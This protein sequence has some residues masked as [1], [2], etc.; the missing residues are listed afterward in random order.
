M[1][2]R[3]CT[4]AVVII[5]VTFAAGAQSQ[6]D[7]SAARFKAHV[8]FLADD[9]L[10]GR[11]AGTRG[12]EIAARYVAAEFAQLGVAP[13]A[14]GGS[15]FQPVALLEVR[16][17]GSAWLTMKTSSGS[18]RFAQAHDVL[19]GG[20]PLGGESDVKGEVVFVGYGITDASLGMDDYKGLDVRGRVVVALAAPVPGIDSEIAAHLLTQQQRIAAEHGAVGFLG[21]QTHGAARVRPFE[22]L[23][24]HADTPSTTWVRKDGTPFDRLHG[25]KASALLGPKAAAALFKGAPRSLEEVLNE[26]ERPEGRPAGFA[27]KA[28]VELRVA[29]KTRR[30]SSPDVVGMIEGSDPALKQEYVAL[31]GHADHIGIEPTGTGDRINNGALDN[32]AGVAT[33]LEVARAFTTSTARPKRSVL[34]VAN[35]AEEKGLLGAESFAN[36]P[37]VPIDRIVAAID[38]DMPLLLYDFTD[39]VAYGAGHSTVERAFQ[40][41]GAQMGVTLSPDP[42]PEQTIFVRSDHYAMAKVGVPAVM[43]ATGM[44]NGGKEAWDSFLRKQYHHPDDDLSLPIHW[45]AGARFAEL[46]YRAVRILADSPERP[47]WYAGDYFGNLFA[48]SATKATK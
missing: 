15:Y 13:G 19:L 40:A 18:Q 12:H 14:A 48:P 38:L 5:L 46:N 27:L 35:T 16:R 29:T 17:T 34:I 9:L 7:F 3:F 2:R 33:L 24:A 41:A 23:A 28:S 42:M 4:T 36:N 44:A 26:A 37:P 10:E 31:M 21:V 11:E 45:T 6:P 25:M 22:M 39:A 30:Y 43:L 1:L 32:G 20:S 8:T 47:L